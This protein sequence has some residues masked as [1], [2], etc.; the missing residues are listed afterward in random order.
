MM[1]LFTRITAVFMLASCYFSVSDALAVPM[2]S[3]NGSNA[4]ISQTY[5]R[6]DLF[7]LD[8]WVSGLENDDLGAFSMNIEFDGGVTD[9][10]SGSFDSNLT[11]LLASPIV[12]STNSVELAGG[13][14]SFDLSNQADAFQIATLNFNAS[15]V[16]TSII[17]IT[18]IVLSDESGLIELDY[19]QFYAAITV[20]DADPPVSVSEPPLLIVL[21]SGLFALAGMCREEGA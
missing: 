15:S 8:L 18:N 19:E 7:S 17:D 12:D 6:G 5:D 2:L 14:L 1:K 4:D 11:D 9:F 10:L 16:G 21:L 3:F 20:V 13:F